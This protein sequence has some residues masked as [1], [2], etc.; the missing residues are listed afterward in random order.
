MKKQYLEKE[1]QYQVE[2]NILKGQLEEKDKLLRFQD[3][4]NIL[5]NILS[6]Q[7]SPTIKS[8]LGF[9]ETVKGESNSQTEA[10]NS[11]AKSETLNKETRGQSHQQPRKES[12]QRKSF[13]PNYGS[14]NRLFPMMNNVECFICHNFGH[15]ASR[16]IS[17]MVQANNRHT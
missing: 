10:R 1:E 6:S 12:I 2:V 14:D 15:V 5:D 13:T 9:H 3:S 8:S 11:N 17:R 4:T 7:R 16:C